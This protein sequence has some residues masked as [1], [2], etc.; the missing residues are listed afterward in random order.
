MKHTG[1]DALC[2]AFESGLVAVIGVALILI[3][4]AAPA[5]AGGGG[6]NMLLIVN[7]SD[8]PSLRIANAYVQGRHIPVNNI[9][10][11]TPINVQ[12]FTY[13]SISGSG[14][15]SFGTAYQ[16]SILSTI[17]SRGL[18]NQ[19]DYIGTLGQ[20]HAVNA[21]NG[22]V[23]FPACVNQLTQFQN[24]MA[25]TSVV[26]RPSELSPSLTFSYIHGTNS[27]FH[28]SQQFTPV[29]ASGT[30]SYVQLY[31]SGMIGYAG[32]EGLT[33]TQVI[34]NLQR[35]I[36][37]DGTKPVGTMYY[38]NYGDERTQAR[39]PYWNQT[40]TYMTANNMPWIEEVLAAPLAASPINRRNVMG[41]EIGIANF[42]TPAGSIYLPGSW[43]DNLTSYGCVYGHVDGQSL[44]D[45]LLLSGAG[46]SSGTIEEPGAIA[47]RF[48]SAALNIYSYDGS[49]LGEAFYKTVQMPD[50]I[51][52]QGDLLSQ[53]YADV[54]SVAFTVAPAD[55]ATV[56][57]SVSLSGSAFLPNLST[58]STAT[59]I[60][61][62]RLFVDGK[63]TGAFVSA[64]TG[65]FILNTTT[66]TD[67]VH[68]A[69]LVAY[70]NSAAASEGCAI[71]NWVVNNLGE[72]VS[73]TGG[74]NY[75]VAANGTVFIPV[76][77]TRGSGPGILGIQ[78]QSLGRIVGSLNGSS[79]NVS[80]SG[81]LLAYGENTI[82]PVVGFSNNQ[83]VQGLPITVSR[84]FQPLAGT[85]STPRANQNPGFDFYYY[86]GV[87]Q[88]TIAATNFS[89]PPAYVLHGST[90]QI[91]P[92]ST[93]PAVVNM[94]NAYR[95]GTGGNNAGLGVMVKSAFTVTT[96][97]E[98]S[99]SFIGA[100]CLWT[101]Y[102]LSIDGVTI[103][104]MDC[105][106]AGT[107]NQICT[108]GFPNNFADTTASAYLLSGEHTL[109]VKLANLPNG[110]GS[111]YDGFMSFQLMFRGLD[112]NVCGSDFNR[113]SY[114]N[115]PYF[116]TV[117]KNVGH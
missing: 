80:L 5:H 40:Q 66:L 85:A 93:Y 94:P 55:G 2:R 95:Q 57:G 51:L 82:T 11:V 77:A 23:S 12:G 13:L 4:M 116:Y 3:G 53:A 43:A 91:V 14:A 22:M 16:T 107:L 47:N 110:G 67:G 106:N 100:N 15:Q 98:Y 88:T 70:N 92:M 105:W 25:V 17:S 27:A 59:G 75:N 10:Y 113:C 49:T 45:N 72:S 71:R 6:E 9:V 19:I 28:H 38:E 84:S 56:S 30:A 89:G 62:I 87:A 114:A 90:L 115:S 52:F 109:I 35:T 32:N 8:E 42:A 65:A 33:T 21:G 39:S 86:P 1:N 117:K 97:G 20:P 46:G 58:Q 24:G 111:T 103:S 108:N 69:R 37:A 31:L 41:A 96:P 63:D 64:G 44:A 26:G 74:S 73:V 101:S 83:R 61:S 18:S 68:E 78:L 29:G 99:F 34:Q 79:G 76:S 104:S 36:A 102:S 112:A 60:A 81:P 50:M 7:P 54:P 48:P